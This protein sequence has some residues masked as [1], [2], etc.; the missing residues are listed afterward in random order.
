MKRLFTITAMFLFIFQGQA[1]NVEIT[2]VI[3]S[4]TNIHFDVSWENS[5]R[6]S[7]DEHDA[8]WIF[9]KLAPNGGP[10]WQHAPISSVTVSTSGFEAE[11]ESD[12]TGFI[13]RR[14]LIGN[15]DVTVDVTAT[16]Y[17]SDLDGAY[18]DVKVT[19]IEVVKIS[20]GSLLRRRS[21]R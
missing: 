2:N 18:R 8:V 10:S 16:L 11:V 13:L 7:T 5:W 6:S 21:I 3:N 19:G 12:E 4:G 14:S 20:A 9:L 1:N 17:Y 15:G